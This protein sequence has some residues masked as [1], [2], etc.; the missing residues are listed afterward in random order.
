M[1]SPVLDA[2]DSTEAEA[3]VC[4]PSVTPTRVAASPVAVGDASSIP[5]PGRTQAA[6]GVNTARG[7]RH[8][9]PLSG[10]ALE[11]LGRAIEYLTDEYIHEGCERG[12]SGSRVEAIQLLMSLNREVYYECP[13]VP[14]MSQRIREFLRHAICD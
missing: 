11:K 3:A 7:R 5:H 1:E 12:L 4:D 8:I 13:L 6:A 2:V 10:Y 14:R 9:P